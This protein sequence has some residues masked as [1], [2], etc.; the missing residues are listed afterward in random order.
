[1]KLI[2]I[3]ILLM[4]G[5]LYASTEDKKRDI[6]SMKSSILKKE[7]LP[8]GC[9]FEKFT[10]DML[11]YE[12]LLPEDGHSMKLQIFDVREE[13]PFH[14]HHIQTQLILVLEGH[15]QVSDASQ[16]R[17]LESGQLIAIPPKVSHML[18]P[19]GKVRFLAIDLPGFVF[20]EDIYEGKASFKESESLPFISD[21]LAKRSIINDQTHLDSHL[22]ETLKNFSK[23]PREKYLEKVENTGYEAYLL[24]ADDASK[25]SVAI[26][27]LME[28]PSHF[29]KIGIE[30]FIVLGG[31]LHI[32][33]DGISYTLKAGQSVHISQGAKHHLKSATSTPVRLLCVNFPAF[34]PQDFY[35]K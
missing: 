4:Q 21:I 9:R 19:L 1:M 26:L 34:D 10:P 33:L 12:F 15:L 29:H 16:K 28:A 18:T 24:C 5:M 20:P 7:Q 17:I 23:L 2:I 8:V 14:Y 35:L 13:M 32:D 11:I 22:L 25:W 30:H 3:S 31:E 27:D 6:M